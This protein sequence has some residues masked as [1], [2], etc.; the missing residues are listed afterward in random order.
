MQD[1][2]ADWFAL[3]TGW[4]ASAPAEATVSARMRRSLRWR[5]LG[6]RLWFATELLSFL[7]LGLF[8]AQH[9]WMHQLAPAITLASITAFCL[10]AS[11]WARRGRVGGGMHSLAAMIDLTLAR[12]RKTLRL[13]FG[14]YA[15]IAVMLG[16]T[17]GG[18]LPPLTGDEQSLGR[19]A[20]LGFAAVVTVIYHVY[21]KTR[22]RRFEAVRRSLND[23]VRNK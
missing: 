18:A 14:T 4:Q 8:I 19:L 10:A 7:A 9:L 12:A 2:Q 23:E 20:W 16:A 17:F 21:T 3:K 5:I 15:V 1:E 13:V 22:M 11:V 6:S